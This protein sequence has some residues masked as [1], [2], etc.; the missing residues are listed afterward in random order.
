[1]MK[2]ALFAAAAALATVV[3]AAPVMAK[4]VLVHYGDLDLNDAKDQK[5]FA[6]R[7]DRAARKAC[8]YP[9]NGRL[10]DGHSVRCYRQARAAGEN[11]MASVLDQV[12]LGG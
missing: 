1:M 9:S 6:R 11:Q 4:D 12:R 3:T 5:T 8:E 7:I 10:P 2:T